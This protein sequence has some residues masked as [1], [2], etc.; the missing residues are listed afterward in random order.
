MTALSS[1]AVL[2][3]LICLM[4]SLSLIG[5][6]SLTYKVGISRHITWEGRGQTF[7]T[8]SV[9]ICLALLMMS[10]TLAVS[11]IFNWSDQGNFKTLTLLWKFLIFIGCVNIEIYDIW[12]RIY[13]STCWQWS[14]W[15][16]MWPRV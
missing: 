10:N 9:T 14:V 12:L 6:G 16:G 5:A 11:V 13:K 1:A 15:F 8:A 3:A 4:R 7:S 2:A